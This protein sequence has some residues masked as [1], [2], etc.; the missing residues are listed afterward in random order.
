MT[1]NVTHRPIRWLPLAGVLLLAGAV[2]A[3][4]SDDDAT[5]E[6]PEGGTGSVYNDTIIAAESH[7]EVLLD[8]GEGEMLVAVDC[9][10]DGGGTLVTV[11]A[12]GLAEGIYIGTFDPSTGVDLSLQVAGP[13]EAIG[14]S[15]M[16]LD[17]DEY[18][19]T[20]ESVEGAVFDLRG[21]TT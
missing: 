7:D 13:G 6:V 14:Q 17:E 9:D 2:T 11:V 16:T 1:P 19:V 10:P 8:G 4:G 20:F 21:C 12:D 3:C 18:T 5:P 15:Q